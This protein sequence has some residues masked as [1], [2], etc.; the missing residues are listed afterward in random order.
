MGI[1][2]GVVYRARIYR[3]INMVGGVYRAKDTMQNEYYAGC[4]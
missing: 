1:R 3:T 4:G 2:A